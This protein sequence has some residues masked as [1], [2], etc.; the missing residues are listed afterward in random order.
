MWKT[1]VY[2]DCSMECVLKSCR[3]HQQGGAEKFFI[4]RALHK[5]WLKV[6]PSEFFYKDY[7]TWRSVA[8]NVWI[9]KR[10]MLDKIIINW[11]SWIYFIQ[12]QEL[13][14]TSSYTKCKVAGNW[15]GQYKLG[16]SN[17]QKNF[18]QCLVLLCHSASSILFCLTLFCALDVRSRLVDSTEAVW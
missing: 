4:L 12:S 6:Q 14:S 9:W 1:V 10:N 7:K 15:C 2:S 8:K 18:V 11:F 16:Y 5:A 17:S 13:F 3:D